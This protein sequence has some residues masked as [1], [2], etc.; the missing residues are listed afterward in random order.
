MLWVSPI[1]RFRIPKGDNDEDGELL[2]EIVF[3]VTGSAPPHDYITDNMRKVFD[4]ILDSEEIGKGIKS[5]LDFGAGKLKNAPYFLEKGK[6]VCAVE[7]EEL[8]KKSDNAKKNLKICRGYKGLFEDLIFPCPFIEH[9]GK[10]DLAVLINVLPVMPVFAERLMVLQLLYQKIKNDKYLLWYAQKEGSYKSRRLKGSFNCGDGIWMG[11]KKKFKTFYKYHSHKEVDEMMGL[12]GFELV[13]KFSVPGNDARLYK[14]THYDLLDEIL[15]FEKIRKNIPKDESI[16]DPENVS[17]KTVKRTSE[18]S[19]VLPNPLELQI[20]SLYMNVLELF[21]A[22]RAPYHYH[23]LA[24]QIISKVFKGSLKNMKIEQSQDG[25]IKRIDT[26]FSNCAEKGFFRRLADIHDVKCPYIVVEAKDYALDP[27][28]KEFDQ[29]AGRLN[30]NVG[31]FGIL[32]CRSIKNEETAR[33]RCESYLS[34]RKYIIFL[35]DDNLFELLE[36]SMDENAASEIDDFMD[37]KLRKLVFR[38]AS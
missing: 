9:K 23:R 22:G 14:K 7:F 21:Q 17:P 29:L 11:D 6:K 18:I 20:E 26:V 15:T 16:G 3:D 33:K 37:E 35:T 5:V 36:L 25:G 19:E 10:Y 12:C 30:D 27:G 34:D 4:R 2:H 38:E 8:S 24:S 28:N 32:V 31:K 1:Y 13:K